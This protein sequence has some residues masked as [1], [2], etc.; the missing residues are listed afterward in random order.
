MTEDDNK[1]EIERERDKKKKKKKKLILK[2][3]DR[4]IDRYRRQKYEKTKRKKLGIF[5]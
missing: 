4:Q 1:T 3:T 2:K 5:A